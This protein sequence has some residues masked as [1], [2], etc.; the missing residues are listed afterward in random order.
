MRKILFAFVLIMVFTGCS[1]AVPQPQSIAEV[2]KKDFCTQVSAVCAEESYKMEMSKNGI[3]ISFVVTKPEELAGLSI[4]LCGEH[5]KITFKEMQA[6][7][8]T[9][10]LLEKAPFLLLQ[11]LFKELSSADGFV[12]STDGD[13]LLAQ[14]K[15]FFAVLSKEKLTPENAAFSEYETEFEFSDFKFSSAG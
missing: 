4:E 1:K 14:G 5:A 2:Y 11:K 12:L 9:G 8:D 7:I 3:S 13:E 15:D 10:N 6:E